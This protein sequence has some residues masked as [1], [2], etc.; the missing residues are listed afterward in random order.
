MIEI[1]YYPALETQNVLLETG[2]GDIVGFLR[3]YAVGNCSQKRIKTHKLTLVVKYYP[4][5]EMNGSVF[6][7]GTTQY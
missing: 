4:S 5:L 6:W 7:N 2:A 3:V 1:L